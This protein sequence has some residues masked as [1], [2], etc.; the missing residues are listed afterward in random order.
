MG[1]IEESVDGRGRSARELE[2]RSRSSSGGGPRAPGS[3]MV[4]QATVGPASTAVRLRTSAKWLLPLPEGP[5]TQK[6]SR[7][8]THSRPFRASWAALRRAALAESARAAHS[9]IAAAPRGGSTQALLAAS[10]VWV[11]CRISQLWGGIP[12]AS[13]PYRECDAARAFTRQNTPVV[14][15]RGMREIG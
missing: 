8:L 10:P 6:S 15:M 9:Y 3:S 2:R 7:R 12:L 13:R 11:V 4:N 14:Y 1:V 5:Q